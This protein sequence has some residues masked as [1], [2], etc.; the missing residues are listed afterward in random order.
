MELTFKE[1]KMRDKYQIEIPFKEVLEVNQS[2]GADG[3]MLYWFYHTKGQ[4]WGWRNDQ[5]A[6][7]LGWSERTV[8]RVK[9]KLIDAHWLYV[10]KNKG[11]TYTYVGRDR[12]K[13][14][15]EDEEIEK[16]NDDTESKTLKFQRQ[17]DRVR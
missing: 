16:S 9:K 13:E 14:G 15:R 2:V 10:W 3:F 4:K 1:D 7:N 8:Q 12:V 5:V 17:D 6:E 11:N